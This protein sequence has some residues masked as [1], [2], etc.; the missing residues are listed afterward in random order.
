MSDSGFWDYH[1]E[2]AEALRNENGLVPTTN[3]M[4]VIC[5]VIESTVRTDE[6]HDPKKAYHQVPTVMKYARDAELALRVLR[7]NR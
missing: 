2:I 5:A 6:N 4:L 7:K 3:A 1:D